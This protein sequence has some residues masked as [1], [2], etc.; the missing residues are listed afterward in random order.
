MLVAV[1]MTVNKIEIEEKS[2]VNL[3][4][5]K[6]FAMNFL[7]FQKS[8]EKRPSPPQN[9]LKIAKNL[10]KSSVKSVNK[11]VW[12]FSAFNTTTIQ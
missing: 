10:S 5:S 2:C 7:F 1:H 8:C 3:F 9:N 11:K 4:Q 6:I 12:L